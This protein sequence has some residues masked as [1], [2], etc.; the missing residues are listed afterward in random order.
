[1]SGAAWFNIKDTH[2]EIWCSLIGTD[3]LTLNYAG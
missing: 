1:M 3:N 2:T